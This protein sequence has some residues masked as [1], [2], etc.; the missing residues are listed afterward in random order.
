MRGLVLALLLAATPAPVSK[1]RALVKTHAWD[2]LYLAYSAG[3][4]GA[5]EEKDR[6][7]LAALLE[8]GARALQRSDK[9]MAFSLAER[10]LAF[11]ATEEGVLLYAR[12][13]VSIEQRG[14]AEEALTAAVSK[15]P[16]STAVALLLGK[17]LLEDRD[18]AGAA[19][20]LE[21]IPA[22]AKEFREAKALLEKARAS[23]ALEE[24]AERQARKIEQRFNGEPA[25]GSGAEP[26]SDATTGLSYQSGV[27]PGGMRT[28]GNRHFVFRYFNDA[29]DFGQ[30]ADY[31]G[32]V[33]DA[34]EEAWAF[35]RRILGRTRESQV[36]VVLYTRD[37][38][39]THHGAQ[40]ASAVA[41][42]YS[43]NAIRMNDAAEINTESKATLVHEY[44]HAAVDEFAG[45]SARGVPT[46]LNEGLAEYVEWRYLGSDRPP[47]G[48]GRALKSAALQG[49]LPS[50]DQMEDRALISTSNPAIA[51][52]TS[53]VAVKLLL[54]RGGPE[55][56]LGL[57][58]EVGQGRPFDEAF[59]ER[60]GRTVAR[61]D[62]DVADELKSL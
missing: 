45:G 23:V 55:N 49:R 59:Q 19:Q 36:D 62:E 13:A 8:K 43:D 30:R 51:Y 54:K 17:L 37:E 27:G 41:G 25:P 26:A 14:A 16:D 11:H 1:A 42:F 40:M 7:E 58:R 21:R 47:L 24:A 12:I 32:R 44:V 22:K 5:F 28:R 38:F 18:G 61:L 2:E 56:L 33:A 57:L 20:V 6:V 39:I 48:L 31:E 50:L 29:R 35:T 46:W 15:D 4:P 52:G 3:D 34:L 10:A 9:V 53:A 60:Y